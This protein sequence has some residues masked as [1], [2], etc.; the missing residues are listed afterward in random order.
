MDK[1]LIEK[2]A[3]GIFK[4]DFPKKDWGLA[5]NV[6]RSYYLSFSEKAIP[7]IAGEIFGEIVSKLIYIALE[8]PNGTP[9]LHLQ[10]NSYRAAEV[11]QSLRT[12]YG[13]DK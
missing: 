3:E 9:S 1:E 11:W 5:T 10:S 7:L 2:V 12:K 6:C 13:V 8:I 4:Q